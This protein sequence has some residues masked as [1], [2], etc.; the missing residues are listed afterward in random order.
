MTADHGD[1]AAETLFLPL[2]E[3]RLTWPDGG[4]LWLRARMCAPARARRWPQLSCEQSFKPEA[5]ALVR[6]GYALRDPEA[7]DQTRR[8]PMVLL[9]PPR[10]R[11]EAR[12]L[13][14]RAVTCCEPGG[15]VLVCMRNEEGAKS[16]EADLKALAGLSGSLSKQHCRV[17]WACIDPRR[18][19]DELLS[20]WSG[21]DAPRPI[22]E[23]RFVSRPGVFAWDRIDPASALLAEHLPADLRGRIADLGAGYGY[24]SAEL[25]RKCPGIVA[26]D[27]YEAE[28]RALALARRN[29]GDIA[30]GRALEFFW[31]DVA[32]GLT[33]SYDAIVSNPPFHG[34]GRGARPDIGRAFIMAAAEAL[35][36]G[37]RL[38]MVANRHLPSESVLATHFTAMRVVVD[39]QGFKVIEAVKGSGAGGRGRA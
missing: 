19:D 32:A 7:V 11:E 16:G 17:F 30:S 33:R 20:R 39:A 26:L 34:H 27:L 1:P 25:L 6:A 29:L 22:A 9:L 2:L 31:R 36:T 15:T 24:L 21:L 23:G 18:I 14:A 5:D 37:G 13:M 8:Y 3:S 4:V 35:V 28:A 10:Q 12:A 38:W